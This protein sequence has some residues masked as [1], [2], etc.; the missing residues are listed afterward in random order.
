MSDNHSIYKTL[1]FVFQIIITVCSLYVAL[2]HKFQ[3]LETR[4]T[5]LEATLKAKNVISTPYYSNSEITCLKS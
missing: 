1:P 3:S 2:D 5:I 4:I